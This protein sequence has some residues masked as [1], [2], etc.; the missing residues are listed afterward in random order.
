MITW[1]AKKEQIFEMPTGGAAIMRSGPNLLKLARKEQCLALLCAAA[2]LLHTKCDVAAGFINGNSC[3]D[4]WPSFC[5]KAWFPQLTS[6]QDFMSVGKCWDGF[7]QHGF[8]RVG[9]CGLKLA[10]CLAQDSAA[11]QVQEQRCHLSSVPQWR[12]SVPAP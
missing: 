3:C 12:G 6:S 9:D 2:R 4:L 11:E 7:H 10:V 5:C 1:E 8:M